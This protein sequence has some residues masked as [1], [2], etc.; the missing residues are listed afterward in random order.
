MF[1]GMIAPLRPLTPTGVIWYQGE[2][3]VDKGDYAKLL[4]G[5]I[6]NWRKWFGRE[7]PFIVVQLPNFGTIA[8]APE[9]STWANLRNIQQQVALQDP[10]VGLVVTQ[11]LGDDGDLHPRLKYAVATRT[12][13]VV[14]AL[15]GDGVQDGIIPRLT[16]TGNSLA[17]EFSP[18]ISTDVHEKP[19][20]GFA[21]CTAQAGS[22]VAAPAMQSGNR[23]AINRAVL[24]IATR[25][26][27]CW[28]DGGVCEL[29]SLAGLPVASFELPLK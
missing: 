14:R 13:Q 16:I 9:E 23:V 28:S 20:A 5:L 8:K 11:D 17:L 2:S 25:V 22:C 1:N 27:Y 10:R 7:L 6:H 12:L 21:L 19:I 29:R 4:P 3:N 26:R 24:P 15:Q 18:P